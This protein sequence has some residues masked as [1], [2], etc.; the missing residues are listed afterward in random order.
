MKSAY[1]HYGS[2]DFVR[3]Q[4]SWYLRKSSVASINYDYQILMNYSIKCMEKY[5]VL[6]KKKKKF[7]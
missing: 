4:E 3:I 1:N 6:S 7:Y 5:A 2:S